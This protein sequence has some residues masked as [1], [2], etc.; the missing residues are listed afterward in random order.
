VVLRRVEGKDELYPFNYNDVSKGK[1]LE[2]NR[3]LLPG[4]VVVVP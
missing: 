3:T 2:Q 4:D 1:S